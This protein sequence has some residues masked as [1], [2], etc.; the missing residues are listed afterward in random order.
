MKKLVLYL[1]ST[2]LAAV[3]V[4]LAAMLLGY[5]LPLAAVQILWINVVT[6]TAVTVNLV[7]DPPEAGLM[8]RPPVPRGEPLLDR[9]LFLRVALMTPVIAVSTFGYFAYQ[10]RAGASLE[11][12]RTATFT[13]LAVCLWF[14]ALNCRSETESALRFGLL[15][16][17]WLVG[18]LVLGNLLQAAVVFVPRLNAVFHTVPLPLHHVFLIGAVGS[19]VLWV[20][21]LRKLLARRRER[22]LAR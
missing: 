20:E 3:L 5:P 11:S 21:E 22:R 8:R 19:V 16:N 6:E 9:E 7:M 14:N 15:A 17:R 13:V 4:L 1:F 2:S 10:L 18:G 12:A